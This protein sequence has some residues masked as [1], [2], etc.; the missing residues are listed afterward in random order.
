MTLDRHLEGQ[1]ARLN[2]PVRTG[3]KFLFGITLL[4]NDGKWGYRIIRKSHADETIPQW[5]GTTT[6]VDKQIYETP[7]LRF[8]S[9]QAALESAWKWL[10]KYR[11]ET[12]TVESEPEAEE[13]PEEDADTGEDADGE[14]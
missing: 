14:G 12:R 13:T 4:E 3:Q 1:L 7:T 2:L 9:D 6:T 10:E 11:A 8:K 5:K